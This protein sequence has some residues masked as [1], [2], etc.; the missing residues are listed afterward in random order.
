MRKI[1][2]MPLGHLE[3]VP[4]H[5]LTDPQEVPRPFDCILTAVAALDTAPMGVTPLNGDV[6][7]TFL[8]LLERRI[9]YQTNDGYDKEQTSPLASLK[10]RWPAQ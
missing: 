1:L 9:Y 3:I 5:R 7:A 10:A 4:E 8:A 6:P 2:A